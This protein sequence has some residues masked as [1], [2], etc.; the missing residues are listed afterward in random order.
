MKLTGR[1]ENDRMGGQTYV[2]KVQCEKTLY[3]N[4][5]DCT[6][7]HS[8]SGILK[9]NEYGSAAQHQP[10]LCDCDYYI[11]GSQPGTGG[12]RVDSAHRSGDGQHLQ[13]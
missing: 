4:C 1:S 13:Y 2:F 3:C 6:G 7:Y 11:S 8:G 12:E 5:G 10:S 9:Q